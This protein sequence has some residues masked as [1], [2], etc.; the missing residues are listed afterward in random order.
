MTSENGSSKLEGKKNWKYLS[1][2]SYMPGINDTNSS[3]IW[4]CLLKLTCN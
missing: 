1:D 4:I 3:D 2:P